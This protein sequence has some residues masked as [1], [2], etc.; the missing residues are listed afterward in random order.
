MKNIILSLAIAIAL[1]SCKEETKEKVKEAS[2]AVGTEMKES[3]DSVAEKAQSAIDTSKVK[4]KPV[5]VN[6][7]TQEVDVPVY[8]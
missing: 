8:V 7:N 1:V 4:A 5:N 3:I 2:V 6:V